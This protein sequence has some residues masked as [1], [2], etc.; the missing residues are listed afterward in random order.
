MSNPERA[1]LLVV[2]S[3][4][5]ARPDSHLRDL[6]ASMASC[7]AGVDF[8][9]CLVVNQ[10]PGVAT[11]LAFAQQPQ[12]LHSRENSGMNIGAWDLGWRQH[13]DYARYLFLQDECRIV[14]PGWGKVFTET[15]QQTGA[16]L[17]TESMNRRWDR[18]WKHL[19]CK[20]KGG[21]GSGESPDRWMGDASFYQAFMR[22]HGIDPGTTGRHAR[23]LVWGIPG[24]V[25]RKIDGFP[26]GTSYAECIAS[27]IA[28]SRKI[29]SEGYRIVQLRKKPF[30]F[31]H[32]MEW[33]SECKSQAEHRSSSHVLNR[34][35][36]I[37]GV[38][39]NR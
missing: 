15:M 11:E 2:V 14:S 27:E 20:R 37:F 5:N 1:G 22:Q 36:S 21:K 29:A 3:Y 4:Y 24:S 18:P 28:V 12:Y 9:V 23:A 35:M 10:E 31:I 30:S 25:M 17:V 38:G 7:E 6:L 26:L 39:R 32:H 13:P 33:A 8:D 34:V 19:R 16:G